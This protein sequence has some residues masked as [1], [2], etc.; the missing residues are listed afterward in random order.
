[1][2]KDEAWLLLR[3]LL[4]KYKNCGR[5]SLNGRHAEALATVIPECPH[6]ETVNTLESA[7]PVSV[8]DTD[9]E[10]PE[11]FDLELS[12]RATKL[13]LGAGIKYV[14]QLKNVKYSELESIKN[15]SPRT[16]KEIVEVAE[17][18]GSVRSMRYSAAGYIRNLLKN[19]TR[20]IR[21]P[22]CRR[23]LSSKRR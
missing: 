3:E 1:M 8:T 7:E 12:V 19:W 20:S 9:R 4:E 23:L 21:K 14:S 18:R 15:M 11:I 13:L 17:G 6:N 5:A 2:G 10:D 16:L 22:V